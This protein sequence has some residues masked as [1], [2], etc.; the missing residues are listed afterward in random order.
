MAAVATG[1]IGETAHEVALEGAP[2]ADATL[3]AALDG[4]LEADALG[5]VATPTLADTAPELF[6]AIEGF[7]QQNAQFESSVVQAR[8]IDAIGASTEI[9]G[10]F[11][12]PMQHTLISMDGALRWAMFWRMAVDRGETKDFPS[13]AFSCDA[14]IRLITKIYDLGVKDAIT[15]HFEASD[16]SDDEGDDEED[17]D[18]DADGGGIGDGIGDSGGDSGGI[19]DSTSN[20][21]GGDDVGAEYSI[22]AFPDQGSPVPAN[23]EWGE[24]DPYYAEGNGDGAA[25]DGETLDVI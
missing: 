24:A 20:V 4:I 15:Q 9:M 23:G 7:I 5:A 17:D 12:I 13:D 3:E 8:V 2:E 18:I 21:G 16:D 6:D 11:A 14:A 25:P 19:G 1:A 22:G 10:A